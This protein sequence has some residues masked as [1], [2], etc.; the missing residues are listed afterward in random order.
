MRERRSPPDIEMILTADR[1][2]SW[3]FSLALK[4][5]SAEGAARIGAGQATLHDD[6][7][8]SLRDRALLGRS[9]LPEPPPAS[10]PCG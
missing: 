8:A 10:R 5:C 7:S 4:G 9:G 6:T 2:T 3:T 1:S